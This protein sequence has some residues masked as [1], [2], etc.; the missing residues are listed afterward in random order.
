MPQGPL[1]EPVPFHILEVE[2]ELKCQVL[3]LGHSN[4]LQLQ[5]GEEWLGR[6]QQE[7]GWGLPVHSACPGGQEG[8]WL[9]GWV[10]NGV[11]SRTWAVTLPLLWAL[12][13][14]RPKGCVQFWAWHC[15]MDI[16]GLERV[17]RGERRGAGQ[18]A[19]AQV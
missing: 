14:P 3:P 16:E 8:Q 19:G 18:E 17:Q 15:K 10:S 7:K 5:A 4:P 9:L 2:Q 6:A 1:S 12:G 11:A 13:R